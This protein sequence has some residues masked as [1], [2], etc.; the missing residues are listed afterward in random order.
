MQIIAYPKTYYRYD[1][2]CNKKDR[3]LSMDSGG[4]VLVP[5]SATK[6]LGDLGGDQSKI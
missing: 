4:L 5:D 2:N 3:G 6:F 1:L